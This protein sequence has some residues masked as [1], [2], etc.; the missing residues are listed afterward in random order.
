MPGGLVTEP[1]DPDLMTLATP[2]ALH[3]VSQAEYD[4]IERQLVG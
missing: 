2:Y 3:A 1:G 4:E